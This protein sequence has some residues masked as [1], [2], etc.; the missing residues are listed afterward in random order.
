MRS[1]SGRTMLV[2]TLNKI[3]AQ[4]EDM[5]RSE[6]Y[7]TVASI[8]SGFGITVLMFRIERELSVRENHPDW[9]N[10][11]AWA[12]Y[13]ILGAIVL[14]LLVVVLPVVGLSEPSK[15][16]LTVAAGS[17]AASVILVAL[18][19]FAILAHYR[20]LIG[21]NRS[22]DRKKGEPLERLIVVAASIL[23]AGVFACVIWFGR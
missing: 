3:R 15:W 5:N 19:P 2:S 14:S 10:W 17:C 9:P 7:L 6:A 4:G 12:D 13:L 8:L 22:G 23:A 1:L 18:Y 11:L 16:V 21:A 20:I